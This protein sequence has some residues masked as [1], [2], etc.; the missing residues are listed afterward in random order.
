M[1]LFILF[2][3]IFTIDLSDFHPEDWYTPL[4]SYN[5]NREDGMVIFSH[6]L[7]ECGVTNGNI[8]IIAPK[9]KFS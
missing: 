7:V 6:N 1:F 4:I 3:F 5:R 8:V 9:L 2:F